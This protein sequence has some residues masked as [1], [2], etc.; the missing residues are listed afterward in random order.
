MGGEEGRN[1]NLKYRKDMSFSC[2]LSLTHHSFLECLLEHG[3]AV[4][5]VGD[6]AMNKTRKA[7]LRHLQ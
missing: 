2:S 7:V 5:E 3:Q 1:Q 6:T 4:F